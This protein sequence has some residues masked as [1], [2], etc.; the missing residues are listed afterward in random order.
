MRNTS[1]DRFIK[2]TENRVMTLSRTKRDKVK[3]GVTFVKWTAS[4]SSSRVS[5]IWSPWTIKSS[6][7]SCE[8]YNVQ[9]PKSVR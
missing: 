7:I 5:F 8:I 9:K 6:T 1:K 2:T 4:W 3:E